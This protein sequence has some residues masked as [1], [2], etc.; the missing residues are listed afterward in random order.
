MEI[1]KFGLGEQERKVEI[2]QI[3]K[4]L[5]DKSKTEGHV[6]NA[7]DGHT[8]PEKFEGKTYDQL[9]ENGDLEE[10]RDNFPEQYS[11]LVKIKFPDKSH[12]PTQDKNSMHE[13]LK[14]ALITGKVTEEL[15]QELRRQYAGNLTGLQGLLDVMP[16]ASP[17]K[18]YQGKNWD[19]LFMSGKLEDVQRY[20]PDHFKKLYKEKFKKDYTGK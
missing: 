6:G 17:E 13:L 2:R 10:L 15:S 14:G 18:M 9:F 3:I 5:I 4:S 20:Y 8:L 7:P 11:K 1:L 16:A 19:D 12:T